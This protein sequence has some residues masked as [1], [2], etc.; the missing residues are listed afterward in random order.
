MFNLLQKFWVGKAIEVINK[1]KEDVKLPTSTQAVEIA[2]FGTIV[3]CGDESAGKS[4][5]LERLLQEEI[6][7]I[8]E[9]IITRAPLRIILKFKPTEFKK[10]MILTIPGKPTLFSYNAKEIHEALKANHNAIRDC[11]IGISGVEA[12]LEMFS[13]TFPNIEIIDLPGLMSF[14]AEG[15]P[16]DLPDIVREIVKIYLKLPNC[17]VLNIIDGKSN[18]RNSPA[19][20]LLNEVIPERIIKVFTKVDCLCDQRQADG[21]LSKFLDKFIK[22]EQKGHTCVALSN[23]KM[24][25]SDTFTMIRETETQFFKDNLDYNIYKNK[26]GIDIL[27]Q[28]LNRLAEESTRKEWALKQK[29]TEEKNLFE[30]ESELT[31]QGPQLTLDEI[32]EEVTQGLLKDDPFLETLIT[33]AWNQCGFLTI[34]TQCWA[35]NISYDMNQFLLYFKV[36]VASKLK[37]IFE[38]NPKKLYRYSQFE[39]DFIN[40]FNLKIDERTSDFLNRWDRIARKI[41]LD[42]DTSNNY[43]PDQFVRGVKCCLMS[44]VLMHLGAGEFESLKIQLVSIMLTLKSEENSKAA[45]IRESLNLQIR[46]IKDILQ[47][48]PK[49]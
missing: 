21:P 23:Y 17:I 18:Q 10:Q 14:P 26:V 34:S 40:L 8:G 45:Q 6:F 27:L 16:D 25:E 48:L 1:R 2:N 3:V 37:N 33:K 36:Q 31:K 7:E 9:D 15:E 4:F 35:P 43:S 41:W 47:M 20:G 49:N 44:T 29:E 28:H 13:N 22:E 12:K 19:A 42:H 11:G 46:A 38:T 39:I 32:I 5:T 30:I 24:N